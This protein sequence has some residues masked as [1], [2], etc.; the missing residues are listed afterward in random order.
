MP[1]RSPSASHGR[2][3]AESKPSRLGLGAWVFGR[4]G[5]GDQDDRDS[6]AAILRAVEHGVTWIDTAAVYGDGHSERL[7]GRALRELSES[8]R[9]M[10]FTK[11]G[12][13]VDRAGA[14]TFRDL[15]PASLRA[16]CDASIRRL[17][18]DRIDLYQL[19][20]PVDD[21]AV[22]ELAWE[23][24]TELRAEGKVRWCGASNFELE[25]LQRCF[26]IDAVQVPLS[27]LSRLS[28]E[29]V[30]PWATDQGV[31][32]LTY[33]PLES[34]L[35]SGCFSIQ[36]L[37]SLPRSDW[38]HRRAEFQQPQLERSLELVARLGPLADEAGVTVTELAIA[39]TLAW[40]GVGGVIVGA[41]SAEQVD[42]WAGASGVSLD[43]SLL[44]AIDTA[45]RETDAG[46][47]PTRPREP[48]HAP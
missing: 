7:I 38:R 10:V 11:G 23:T 28:A 26:A 27:L 35:L 5:W 42:G 45:L 15:S 46:A 4:T 25:L 39:W 17:G 47:G 43:D 8:E 21:T 13:R 37:Q 19:H 14:G 33:S 3:R 44:D 20:W 32:V 30:L 16:E 22:V 41:R 34:G 29:D 18:V 6:R 36:R 9:P 1:D 24:L 40:P 48:R 31:H 2:R 12:I